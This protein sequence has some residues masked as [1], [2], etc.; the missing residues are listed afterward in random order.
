MKRAFAIIL[1]VVMTT[2][3][4]SSCTLP[5]QS[6]VGTW[7]R[8]ETILGVVTET[9]YVFNEDG[10]GTMTLVLDFDFTYTIE[11][12]QLTITTTTLGIESSEVYT[13]KRSG[14]TLT[15]TNDSETITLE[16]VS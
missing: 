7:K 3:M 9:T 13:Y 8:E 4:L 6:V 14:N 12:N 2:V 16:K 5:W 1:V 15:L 10:T 11:G